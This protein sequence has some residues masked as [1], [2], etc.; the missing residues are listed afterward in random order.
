MTAGGLEQVYAGN[1]HA[2]RDLQDRI[3]F[4]LSPCRLWPCVVRAEQQQQPED[5]PGDLPANGPVLP[6]E[7]SQD[8]TRP[9]NQEGYRDWKGL[10]K[11][12]VAML[13]QKGSTVFC[14]LIEVIEYKVG[15]G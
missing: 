6:G 2:H 15:H 10:V 1:L 7:D 14:Q 9:S 11:C 12:R 3:L 13:C 5:C 8:H 4:F